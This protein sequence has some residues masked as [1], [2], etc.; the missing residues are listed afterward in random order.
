[1]GYLLRQQLNENASCVLRPAVLR[2]H[3]ALQRTAPRDGAAA[4][5]HHSRTD[6][7]QCRK[8]Q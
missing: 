7:R 8:G 1:M 3:R 2:L 4:E 6:L 5:Q